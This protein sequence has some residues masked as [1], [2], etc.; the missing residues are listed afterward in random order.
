MI[1]ARFV[2]TLPPPRTK[3][4]ISFMKGLAQ[5]LPCRDPCLRLL[6]SVVTFNG[7][8]FDPASSIFFS[9][10]GSQWFHT[11]SRYLDKH[12]EQH[13]HATTSSKE[14]STCPSADSGICRFQRT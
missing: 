3:R 4:L 12:T 7:L 11:I 6:A 9:R 2:S 8:S 10:F 13:L 1:P 5:H 14:D